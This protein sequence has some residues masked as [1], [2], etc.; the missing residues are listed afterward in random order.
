MKRII[1]LFAVMLF[2]FT[3]NAQ[4]EEY[5]CHL[6]AH[7]T[8]TKICYITDLQKAGSNQNTTMSKI[9]LQ[10]VKYVEKNI[11]KGYTYLY[12][13]MYSKNTAVGM[14]ESAIKSWQEKGYK[15]NYESD[16][17]FKDE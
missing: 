2:A 16:F 5:Y 10:W 6:T 17:R 1:I 12:K 14:R 7:N 3:A 15:I 13:S 11:G 9:Y 8:K 4:K